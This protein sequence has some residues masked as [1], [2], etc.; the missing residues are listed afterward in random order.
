M[1]WF[2]PSALE[3]CIIAKHI[4]LILDKIVIKLQQIQFDLC[5]NKL[6]SWGFFL[7]VYLKN[8]W[9]IV[10]CKLQMIHRLP[11]EKKDIQINKAVDVSILIK[12]LIG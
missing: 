8:V 10:I 1:E 9:F 11:R 3:H 2:S 5:K 6:V 4:K 12:Y 7:I